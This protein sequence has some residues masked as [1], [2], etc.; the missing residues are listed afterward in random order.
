[1]PV[2]EP[3]TDIR[4]TAFETHRQ[5]FVDGQYGEQTFRVCLR[6]LGIPP[7]DIDSEVNLALMERK[8]VRSMT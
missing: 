3:Q 6:L 5:R 7:R 8:P 4:Q 1:M 2:S